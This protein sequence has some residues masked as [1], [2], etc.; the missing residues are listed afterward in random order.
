MLEDL[1]QLDRWPESVKEAQR[2]WIGRSEGANV[3]FNLVPTSVGHQKEFPLT[4]FTTRPDTVYGATFI[5]LSHESPLIETDLLKD[6]EVDRSAYEKYIAKLELLQSQGKNF[7]EV[8]LENIDGGLLL[9]NIKAE[10][11]LTGE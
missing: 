4:I 8:D 7:K 10:H 11:P 6:N 1:D 3:V 2:G 9:R 5:A